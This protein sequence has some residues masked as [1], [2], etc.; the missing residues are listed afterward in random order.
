MS[1]MARHR[2][3]KATVGGILNSA[4]RRSL[5]IPRR[6]AWAWRRPVRACRSFRDEYEPLI[7]QRRTARDG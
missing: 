7:A 1:F 2:W 4:G 5:P 6:R 3:Q